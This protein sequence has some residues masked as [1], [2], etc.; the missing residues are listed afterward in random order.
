MNWKYDG[1]TK[2]KVGRRMMEQRIYICSDCGF[3]VRVKW[4]EKPPAMCPNCRKAV[5]DD[6]RDV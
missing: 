2:V 4:N 5:K 1:Y 6:R 3:S